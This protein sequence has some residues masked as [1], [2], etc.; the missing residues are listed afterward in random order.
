M[1]LIKKWKK[2]IIWLVIILAVVAGGWFYFA[3][4]KKGVEYVTEEAKIMDVQQT[5]SVTG[6]INP[7]LMI[8]LGFK[9]SGVIQEM[10]VDIG[11]EVKKGQR[12]ARVSVGTLWEE[13]KAS[14]SDIK[15][16]KKTLDH[17]EDNGDSY[18]EEQEDAQKALVKKAE[19]LTRA[20]SIRIGD[21]YLY[22][23]MKGRIIKKNYELGE[24][25]PLNSVVLV[26]ADGELE[27]ESDVPESD[28]I[29]LALGQSAEITLDAFP[30]EDKFEAEIVEIEP[31][32]TVIQDVVYYK[33]K[34]KFK[35]LDERFKTGM[36]CDVDVRTARKERVVA[37]PLRAVKSEAGRKYVEI[38]KDEKN[39]LSEKVFIATGLEGDDGIVEVTAGLKGGE[40]VIT[41]TSEK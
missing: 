8:D 3:S 31:A 21:T 2:K 15:Y 37:I 28:I 13:K 12:L 6:V 4:Q 20:S 1:E 5:V 33:V 30:L 19:A 11:E 10:N 22:A 14:E 29:K 9:T 39:N 24:I 35:S 23:P 32:S 36:S 34:L 27:I 16:Q 26:L 41:L 18:S 38:L 7:T 25:A 17:I 40:R